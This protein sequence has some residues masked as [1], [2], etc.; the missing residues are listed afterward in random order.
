[1]P[2]GTF[3]ALHVAMRPNPAT[4]LPTWPGFVLKV[5]NQFMPKESFY[6]EAAPPHR[7]LRFEGVTGP[8]GPKI[9]T[10][11]VRYWTAG[12]SET[13]TISCSQ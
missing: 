6:F 11:L 8:T 13:D 3:R 12:K 10:E 5:I 7:F 9:G 2:A 1:M 4:F